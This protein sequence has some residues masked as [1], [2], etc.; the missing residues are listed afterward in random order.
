M[1]VSSIPGSGRP[2]GWSTPN[3]PQTTKL[4]NLPM[5]NR[6]MLRPLLL[7]LVFLIS[8]CAAPPP[9]TSVKPGINAPF[10]NP[11]MNVQSFVDRFEGESREIYA[12]RS[13]ITQA[14]QI[15][16]GMDVA[17]IGAGTGLF[18]TSF[19]QAV[20]PQGTVYA[21]DLSPQM[22]KHLRER[23]EKENLDQ[24]S[25]VE[26]TENS[27]ELPEQSVDLVFICDTYHHFEFPRT[28]MKTVH[29]ALRKDGEVVIVDFERIPEKTQPWILNH[30][31]CGKQT[32]IQ[33]MESF[34]FEQIEDVK[35][36]GLTDNYILRFRKR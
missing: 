2:P 17:D 10:L 12:L 1:A 22:L 18:L 27:A 16:T 7:A 32:V 4:Q 28:T 9:E 25:V 13:E 20:G 24:V 14:S 31:R 23:K 29:D 15:Q 26:C 5:Q 34:G 35:L 3:L 6:F 11:E 8:A 33:E 21:V 30:V 36:D 19:S